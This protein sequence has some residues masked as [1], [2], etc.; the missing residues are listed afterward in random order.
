MKYLVD[1]NVLSETTKIAP[2]AKAVKWLRANE[3]QLV[4]D[5]IILGEIQFGIFLLP[6]GKR[7]RHL[8]I[9]FKHAIARIACLPWTAETSSV[10]AK[11]VAT[12][13]AQGKAIPIKYS[14]IAATALLHHLIVVTGNTYDF[15]EAGV[16]VLNPFA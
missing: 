5:P 2:N 4:V 15:R 14:L 6:S 16:K 13:R 3:A 11:L 7:R 8:E 10:W 12:L 1:A 9:W